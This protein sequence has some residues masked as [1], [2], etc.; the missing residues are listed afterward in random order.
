MAFMLNANM[1]CCSFG[2]H[3]G[4]SI[5]CKQGKLE[6]AWITSR[7]LALC[8]RDAGAGVVL[9]DGTG[10]ELWDELR[11]TAAL[12]VVR[13]G[14]PAPFITTPARIALHARAK[15]Q[16]CS[17]KAKI[18]NIAKQKLPARKICS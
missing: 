11:T 18:L 16:T 3:F 6:A 12:N 9:L 10:E 5:I 2:N 13:F 15:K 8:I 4:S 7:D 14:R 17:T 1:V